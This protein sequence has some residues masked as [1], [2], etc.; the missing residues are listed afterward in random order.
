M[1]VLA[2]LALVSRRFNSYITPLLHR[3]IKI[4]TPSELAT[5]YSFMQ[6][7][8]DGWK[9]RWTTL[10]SHLDMS[11]CL[12]QEAD[13]LDTAYCLHWTRCSAHVDIMPSSELVKSRVLRRVSKRAILRC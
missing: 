12:G 2:C 7:L 13:A 6:T 8:S 1:N 9:C 11:H 10:R 5:F 3:T 4:T